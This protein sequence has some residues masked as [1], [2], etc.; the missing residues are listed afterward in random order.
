MSFI[1]VC[2]CLRVC[3]CVR[4][5]LCVFVHVFSGLSKWVRQ[6][7]QHHDTFSNAMQSLVAF[8]QVQHKVEAASAVSDSQNPS[9]TASS[10]NS[11][12]PVTIEEQGPSKALG[13]QT[14]SSCVKSPEPQVD[15]SPQ[16]FHFSSHTHLKSEQNKKSGES[17]CLINVFVL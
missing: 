3:V 4:P 5:C 17:N 15:T 9:S 8:T 7:V 11:H 1:C 13:Q 16:I 2:V 6:L 10:P 14:P 12:V